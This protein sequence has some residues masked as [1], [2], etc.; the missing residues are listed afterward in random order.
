MKLVDIYCLNC[1]SVV[2]DI[3]LENQEDPG[4][5]YCPTCDLLTKYGI[6]CNGGTGGRWR[7]ND[8]PSKTDVDYYSKCVT[9]DGPVAED[10]DGK[11]I[12]HYRTGERLDKSERFSED[13]RTE[14]RE[15]ILHERK[16]RYGKT[17][18]YIDLGRKHG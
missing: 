13:S 6:V 11:P 7:W 10:A 1:R 12:T 9:S 18:I 17:N 4:I 3:L 16:V 14:R 8:F 15:R 5:R 2:S